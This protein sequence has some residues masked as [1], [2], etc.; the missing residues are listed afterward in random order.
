MGSDMKKKSAAGNL[1]A[2][3]TILVWGTTFISTKVLL[4]DFAPVE[5]LFFRFVLGFAALMLVYPHRMKLNDRKQELYFAAAGICG[6]TL[7]FL[8]ENI[9]LTFT[10]ASNV[11]I[12]V[13]VS[14]FFTAIFSRLFTKEKERTSANFFVGFVLAMIG[15]S[16][17]TFNGNASFHINPFGDLLAVGASIVW[18]AY[19][20]LTKK[21]A[22]FGYH[23]IPTTRRIFGYGLFFMVPA[24]FFME[25][26]LELG[27]FTNP[28]YLF[29]VLFLGLLASALCFVTWN[30]AVEALGPVKTSVFMYITPV[31]TVITSVIVL[32]ETITPMALVGIMLTLAGLFISEKKRRVHT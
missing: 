2:L 10:M 4:K 17:I 16:L 30:F 24:L 5:I 28:V 1:A 29:N 25:F 8:L 3:F 20:V 31:V 6:V 26:H 7:Y 27:R 21:I 13:T 32:K 11:G 14:P 19:S 23:V 18:A 9:A 22:A 15:V 12:I